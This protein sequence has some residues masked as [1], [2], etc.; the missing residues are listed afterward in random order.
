MPELQK[1]MNRKTDTTLVVNF[2]ATWC[3]PCIKELPYFEQMNTKYARK[4]VKVV[5]VSLDVPSKLE[6]KVKPFVQ[7]NKFN[8]TVLLLNEPDQ[9]TW[10]NQIDKDW[11]GSLP[12]TI[13]LNNSRK[14]R[15]TFEQAFT[16]EELEMELLTFLE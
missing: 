7:K 12:Y 1:L 16:R 8:S 5:M 6:G 11:S 3:G 13:V 14:K 2:W 10:I 9:N 4:K 15:K